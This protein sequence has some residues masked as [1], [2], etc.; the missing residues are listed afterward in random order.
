MTTEEIQASSTDIIIRELR[1]A[2]KGR[3]VW[4]VQEKDTGNYV[5]EFPDR[6]DIEARDWWLKYQKN[7]PT[8]PKNYELRR[9]HFQTHAE[10]LMLEAA[11]RLERLVAF[12]KTVLDWDATE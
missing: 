5:I 2:A 1:E 11:D 3:Y 12:K 8:V 10:R 4:R 7:H 9:V 6:E